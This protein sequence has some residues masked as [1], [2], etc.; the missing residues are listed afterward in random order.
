[1]QW[2]S[3]RRGSDFEEF[4]LKRG[5]VLR[6]AVFLD[7]DGVICEEVGYLNHISRLQ[8][9]PFAATAIRK[10]NDARVPVFVVTNQSGIS[11]GM[12]PE[13]LVIETHERIAREMASQ[14]ARIDDFYYCAHRREDDCSCR[15][16]LPG[17]LQRAAEKHGLDLARSYVVGDRHGD[18]ELA[19]GVG[20]R[21]IL[22]LTGYGRGEY[23]FRSAGWSRQPDKVLENLSY[24]ADAILAELSSP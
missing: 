14:G 16:P 18:I 5:N 2:R 8:I 17:L 21:A 10:L 9:F 12:F 6:P 24:A 4:G 20:A 22:V 1:V 13:S 19:H 11:R 23:E 15:K 7:R 3:T